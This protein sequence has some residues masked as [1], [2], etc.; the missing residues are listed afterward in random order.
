MS[1]YYNNNQYYR[2]VDDEDNDESISSGGDG[3]DGGIPYMYAPDGQAVDLNDPTSMGR[4]RNDPSGGDV[5]GGM[6]GEG[7][8]GD[9]LGGMGG[10]GGHGI[11]LASNFTA[12]FGYDA[13]SPN[14]HAGGNHHNPNVVD[15][16]DPRI[17]SLPRILLMG[18]RRAGKT[19]IQRVVFH[20]M[21]PHETL[22]RLEATQMLERAV[23][24]HTPLCRFTIWD[25]PG[26]QYE[27]SSGGGGYGLGGGP[28][29]SA[30]KGPGVDAAVD[31]RG[32]DDAVEPTAADS[33]AYDDQIFAKATALIFVLDAQDEPYDHVLQSFTDTV[34][35]AVRANP[36]IAVEVFVHKV[37]GEL[38]L[39]D[40]AKYDCRRDVMQ[41][42]ADELAD[43]GLS[44]D[45]IPISYHLTSIYDHSV[46]EAF[47][48]VVQRLIPELPTLEH[49]LNVLVSTCSMEKAYLFDV[50]SK[51]YISTDSSPV[52]MQSVELCSDMI[53]VVLDVSGI[54]GLGGQSPSG[55]GQKNANR[56]LEDGKEIDDNEGF[57]SGD[58]HGLD[59][60]GLGNELGGDLDD[61]DDVDAHTDNGDDELLGKLVGQ[62]PP[63]IE[64]DDVDEEETNDVDAGSAY[65]SESSS[66]I[67]LSNGMVLY[68]K[69]VDTML[70]LVCL[71]RAENFRKKS[72]I[73]YNIGCL[74][75][76]LRALPSTNESVS[77]NGM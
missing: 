7:M 26:D 1:N 61:G 32:D 10:G 47:S 5:I 16:D 27:Y 73:N 35:R 52:D 60:G 8:T 41:Q 36:T 14:N 62:S 68:L 74:K 66:T 4:T 67:H 29:A 34:T 44:H 28:A 12:G 69:E 22:F 56:A 18:P 72:L 20:K 65:D 45:A 38:F 6:T 19:S 11:T 43:A 70:A 15:F 33:S 75:K 30:G 53:D 46:F 24:D 55:K 39:S 77:V 76:A 64:D 49:L 21:S 71:T 37:D 13:D 57:R 17:A 63:S 9:A 40:E 3:D 2:D 51:L 25:F 23:V 50:A 58:D 31:G 59:G 48:R 42:V 54:Y